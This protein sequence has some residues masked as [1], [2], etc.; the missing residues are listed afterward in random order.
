MSTAL[1]LLMLAGAFALLFLAAELL[2]KKLQVPAETTR[3]I[4]HFETGL[5]TLLFPVLLESIV[6]VG[7]LCG[8]FLILLLASMRF[9]ML[10]SINAIRRKSW[11]SILYPVIV[12]IVYAFFD[13]Y[14][15][16][17]NRL[18]APLYYF[19]LPILVMAICDPIAALA[20][21]AFRKRYPHTA[22]GKTIAGSFAFFFTASVLIIGLSAYFNRGTAPFSILL[23]IGILLGFMSAL[24]ERFSTGG[25]DNFTIPLSI[26]AGMHIM[27][28]GLRNF[29]A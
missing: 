23:L 29:A 4:I 6:A 7:L 12:F 28:A 26:I 19:Y 3:K 25:W 15:G 9:N 5:L 2:H 11:G 8:I 20:G 16:A 21:N 18:F 24:A 17:G 22:P 10:P 1:S 13:W 27:E 14:A